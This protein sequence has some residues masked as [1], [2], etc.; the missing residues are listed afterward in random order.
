M[1]GIVGAVTLEPE[2]VERRAAAKIKVLI[3]IKK[4]KQSRDRA[5]DAN[6]LKKVGYS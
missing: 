1:V 3:I 6:L 2:G 5:Y 4:I